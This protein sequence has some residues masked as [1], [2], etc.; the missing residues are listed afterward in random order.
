MSSTRE[1]PSRISVAGPATVL[2]GVITGLLVNLLEII[3]DSSSLT[4]LLSSQYEWTL[5]LVYAAAAGIVAASLKFPSTRSRI[6]WLAV[7][8]AVP[9][10]LWLLA[11][12]YPLHLIPLLIMIVGVALSGAGKPETST[13]LPAF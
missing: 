6:I 4:E 11:Q 2:A 9:F 7:I 1:T 5:L 13:S 3:V 10:N 8:P 12:G